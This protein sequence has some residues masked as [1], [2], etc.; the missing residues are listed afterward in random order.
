MLSRPQR[1][2][3]IYIDTKNNFQHK[4]RVKHENKYAKMQQQANNN[5]NETYSKY[6]CTVTIVITD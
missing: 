2:E 1:H 4:T 6:T 3:S 5:I